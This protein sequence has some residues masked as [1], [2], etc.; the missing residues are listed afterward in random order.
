MMKKKI[1]IIIKDFPRKIKIKDEFRVLVIVF[2]RGRQ[3]NKT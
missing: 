2:I 1:I 3:T